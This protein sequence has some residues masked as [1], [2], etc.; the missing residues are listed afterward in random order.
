MWLCQNLLCNVLLCSVAQV[1]CGGTCLALLTSTE[2]CCNPNACCPIVPTPSSRVQLILVYSL[3]QS[4]AW[5]CPR[6]LVLLDDPLRQR[7]VVCRH[8]QPSPALCAHQVLFGALG[9]PNEPC[10]FFSRPYWAA[11][12]W[13]GLVISD[14]PEACLP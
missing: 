8:Q 13:V 5:E 10:D 1:V 4:P 3:T 9:P 2:L 12:P 6:L 14:L 7:W 11:V